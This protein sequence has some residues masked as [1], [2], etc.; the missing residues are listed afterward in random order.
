MARCHR[1]SCRAYSN[2]GAR[3]IYVCDRWRE[4]FENFLADMGPKPS[5]AHSIDRIDNN[6]GYSP[7]NCR[8]ATWHEQ[9]RNKRVN[10]L[11]E[12]RGKRQ[13][14]TDWARDTGI[15]VN[16]LRFRIKKGWPVERAL[17]EG[18]TK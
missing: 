8:W 2:Y 10:L 6:L 17:T 13:C 11:V 12:H 15:H 3:G 16:T 9:S 7:E 14:L 18:A 5:P 4:S 1:P